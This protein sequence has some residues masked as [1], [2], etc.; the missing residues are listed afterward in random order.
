MALVQT[1]S[2]PITS[3]RSWGTVL[4]GY[5]ALA[6]TY[7]A[8]EYAM[9]FHQHIPLFLGLM[10]A[11]VPVAYV[12]ARLQGFPGLK[13]WGMQFNK[14]YAL[15]LLVGLSLGLLVN[16]LAF[17]VRLWMGIEVVSLVPDTATL[18]T[19]TLLF[20]VGTFLPSLAEDILTRGYLFGHLQGKLSK[21]GFVLVS[22]AVYVLNHIYSLDDG[23]AAL[24]YLSAL[25]IML[26]IPL[27]YT[28]NL[29]YT[30]GA[31]WAGNIV[32][33]LGQDVLKVEEGPSTFPGLWELTIF[34]LLFAV[35]NYWVSRRMAKNLR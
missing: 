3:R 19:Q 29:W 30:V 31:H 33:R 34:V 14:K 4:G 15:L 6:L 18:L 8:A 11:V 23:F 2:S 35:V 16:G 24:A 9:R 17:A 21:W 7:H 32:Y 12:V 27:V 22:S 20:A 26:A 28:R 25:G 13:A 5:L 10:L 1:T